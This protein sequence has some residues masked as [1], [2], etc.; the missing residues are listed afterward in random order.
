MATRA[1]KA[2]RRAAVFGCIRVKIHR[3]GRKEREEEETKFNHIKTQKAQNNSVFFCG[4]ST[5]LLSSS[6]PLR[7]SR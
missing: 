3:K 7:T 1:R 5:F 4:L 2:A 6:R